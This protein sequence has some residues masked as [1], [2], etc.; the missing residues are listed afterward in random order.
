MKL[1]LA[2]PQ[3]GVVA[4]P[5]ATLRVAVEAEGMGFDSLWV[6]DRLLL[7]VRPRDRYIT[8]DGVI[9]SAYENFL[10]PLTLLAA[11]ATTT[12]RVRLGTSTLN[13]L[14]QP[15]ALLA[16]TVTTLDQL[17]GGRIDLGIG[18][19]WLRDE[20]QAAGVPWEGRGARLEETLDVLDAFWS[21]DVVTHEGPLWTV[22]ESWVRAK[23]V[24]RPPI[25]LAG[26]VPAAF[27]RIARRADG[28]L[29]VGLPLPM[30]TATI[31]SIR[32]QAAS[33]GR[34]PGAL[35]F[36]LRINPHITAEQADDAHVPHVGTIDQLTDYVRRVEGVVDEVFVDFQLTAR[37]VDEYLDLARAVITG[38]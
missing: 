32:Q 8:P 6:S 7:P 30:L 4:D 35:R 36:P 33:F 16:R 14:W 3:Y 29:A 24:R 15:P 9:P 11:V 5:S 22:P 27:T 23:P 19:G 1:G 34:D 38:S 10:D 21:N 2:L 13:A 17:S 26:L 31:A 37:S 25:L 20:Y 28:W 18:V 12:S